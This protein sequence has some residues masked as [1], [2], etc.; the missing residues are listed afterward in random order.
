[1]LNNKNMILP[2]HFEFLKTSQPM[3]MDTDI[4]VGTAEILYGVALNST[5]WWIEEML[6][7][8]VDDI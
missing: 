6:L 5:V 7:D 8:L 3:Q 1:M 4:D 2:W